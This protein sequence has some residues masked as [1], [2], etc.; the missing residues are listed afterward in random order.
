MNINRTNYESWFLD[1]HEGTLAPEQVAALFAF[2][3]A[4]PDLREEFE[5]FEMIRLET[6][7]QAIS[8]DKTV[9]LKNTTIDASNIDEWLISEIEGRLSEEELNRLHDYLHQHPQEK[10]RRVQFA[11]TRLE[12]GPEKHPSSKLLYSFEPIGAHNIDLWLIAETEGQ[13][14]LQKLVVLKNYLSAHPSYI[15]DR[16]L[17][18]NT[19]LTPATDEHFEQKTS[20]YRKSAPVVSLHTAAGNTGGTL[21]YRSLMRIAAV[22][23]LLLGAYLGIRLYLQPTANEQH[24]AETQQPEIVTPDNRLYPAPEAEAPANNNT[25][26]QQAPTVF[27]ETRVQEQPNKDIQEPL[28]GKPVLR[29]R[30]T[31]GSTLAAQTPLAPDTQPLQETERMTLKTSPA[32]YVEEPFAFAERRYTPKATPYYNAP[33]EPPSIRPAL[34]LNSQPETIRETVSNEINEAAGEEILQRS[35][36]PDKLT[37]GSR[38]IRL[39][40]KAVGKISGEKVK[41]RTVFNPVTGKLSAYELQTKNKSWQR[42]F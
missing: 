35:K 3:E 24:R 22:L 28:P 36:R 8:F 40:A 21:R 2:L 11:A 20:L 29:R 25:P 6:D 38:I 5:A 16:E 10:T 34:Q 33:N 14:N 1:Y 12:A 26:E 4:H 32:L 23:L 37:F 19:H 27:P 9:L 15:R 31:P 39:A 17:Y 42:Q 18:A 13:L 41:V 30:Y 7:D